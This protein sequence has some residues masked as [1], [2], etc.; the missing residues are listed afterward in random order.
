MQIPNRVKRGRHEAGAPSKS[1]LWRAKEFPHGWGC[2]G[3]CGEPGYAEAFEHEAEDALMLVE[4]DGSVCPLGKRTDHDGGYVA[5][6]GGEVESVSLVEHDDQQTIDLKL[7]TVD[8]RVDVRLQPGI[9]GAERAV[10]R[11]V[12][13]IG[14]D[15]GIIWKVGGVQIDGKLTEGHEVLRLLGIV[16]HVGEIGER[17]VADGVAPGVAAGVADRWK[18]FGVRLPGLARGEKVTDDVVCV[19]GEVMGRD[20]VGERQRREC[21]SGG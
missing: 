16:L 21:L 1:T 14:D 18:I 15:E 20:G 3:V 4:G 2:G 19:D 6:T 7:R 8:E 5:A 13:K 12:A 17:I 9:G 10:V 11:V